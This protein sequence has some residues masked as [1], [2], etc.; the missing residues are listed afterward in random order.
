ML[1]F[2]LLELAA[3][4]A[5]AQDAQAESSANGAEAALAAQFAEAAAEAFVIAGAPNGHHEKLAPLAGSWETRI[6]AWDAPESDPRTG[7]GAAVFRWVMDG[8]FLVEEAQATVE[9]D[10]IESFGL[11]GFDNLTGEYQ[12]IRTR[13]SLTSMLIGTGSLNET[14][15]ELT[16]LSRYQ[17]PVDRGWIRVRRVLGL[18][19]EDAMR[20]SVF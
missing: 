7:S 3:T 1:A 14:R 19:S 20:L 17:D 9:A 6:S 4:P 18:V 8:R 5:A 10:E 12:E 16:L 15:G 11:L 13:A 2:A